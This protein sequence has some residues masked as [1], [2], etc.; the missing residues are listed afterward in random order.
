[1][2]K[3]KQENE[4]EIISGTDT[5]TVITVENEEKRTISQLI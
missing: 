4:S 1:M 5:S 2:A 3:E